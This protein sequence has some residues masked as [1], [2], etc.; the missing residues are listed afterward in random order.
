[1]KTLICIAALFV[2]LGTGAKSAYPQAP[3][4]PA[5]STSS[6]S[7]S[8]ANATHKLRDFLA[9]DWKYWMIE[10]PE[11]AT[12]FG[13]PG[14][15]SRWTDFSPAAIE[16][17]VQHLKRSIVEMKAIPRD[18]LPAGEQL[19]Y[20]LYLELLERA[21][22]GLRFHH[23]SLPMASV[24]PMNLYMPVNQMQ[25]VLQDV[26]STISEMPTVHP[27][28]YGDILARLNGVPALID[29]VIALM[30]VGMAQ[31][32]MPPKITMRDVPQ[33]AA[34]QIFSDPLASP[35][36]A[37]FKKYPDTFTDAQKAELT[38]QAK[39]VYADKVSPAFAKLRD[40]LAQTYLPACR[41][42][43][44]VA[45]LPDGA[46]YYKYMVRWQTTTNFT[47][48]Q[49]HQTGLDQ[50]K[51]L[52]AQIDQVAAQAGYAGRTADFEK[53]MRTDP[54]FVATTTEELLMVYRDAAKRADPQLAYLFG[55][56]P[57]LTYGVRA[58]P[59]A[60]APSETDAYYEQGS[61][62]AGRPGYL[63]VNTY[64]LDSRPKWEA[65]DTILHE[66]VPGHHLQ[67]SLAQEM[68]GVPD[69]RQ[70]LS[71]SAYAEGWA[72]YS[73]SLGT[74]MGFY[75]DPYMKFGYLTGQMWRAVRLV[76]DTGMHSMGWTREQSIAYFSDNTG[77]PMQTAVAEID[78]Y[79]VWP[80]QALA[81]KTGQLKIRE[82]RTRA[83]KELG[84]NFNVRA[85][86]DTVVDE[87]AL[88]L[89]L[90]ETR[91]D[92]WIAREKAKSSKPAKR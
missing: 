80:G 15:N 48:G 54:R 18:K 52:G 85:F 44:S 20:D 51:E 65:E 68:E 90:L 71:Y 87:G 14:Q 82:L 27:S 11:E 24:V 34:S 10:E 45:G 32:W 9:A 35:L 76:V 61:P 28:D 13:F 84:T 89:D 6:P 39:M 42:S 33:Q 63:Y 79:I 2:S 36:L 56:L 22:E 3:G 59:D 53:F 38:E 83:E 23:D 30:K 69:F 77:L 70:Q 49:I 40:F 67:F 26:P 73:E 19:N 58:V 47:P 92:A 91:V 46:D 16:R 8:S 12:T 50:V 78:R 74:E 7:S 88:P 5:N 57:R 64:K 55:K 81:Y 21:D 37:A 43:V 60:T 62:A 72:L 1:M 4:S 86:H 66:G 17:R 31:G 41:D 75:T 25:G 29:Q